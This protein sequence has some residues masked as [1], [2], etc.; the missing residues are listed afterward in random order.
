MQSTFSWK[1]LKKISLKV[2]C[3]VQAEPALPAELLG[4]QQSGPACVLL[5]TRPPVPQLASPAGDG[6]AANAR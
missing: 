3:S 6:G 4:V 1:N 2:H 5:P